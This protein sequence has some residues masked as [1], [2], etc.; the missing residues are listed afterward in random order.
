[1]KRI[2][3]LSQTWGVRALV[4]LGILSVLAP[5]SGAG[6]LLFGFL[7][8]AKLSGP[9]RTEVVAA[10]KKTTAGETHRSAP[11]EATKPPLTKK[12]VETARRDVVCSLLIDNVSIGECRNDVETGFQS[13]VLVAVFVS[14]VDPPIGQNIEITVDG[15]TKI[16]NP[17]EKGCANYVQF[18][19]DADGSSQVA[20]AEFSGG[21]C[22][23]PSVIFN[24]P[25]EC[26]G[27]APC[28]GA[29]SIGGRV[30][31]DFDSD[32]TLDASEFGLEGAQ[33][34]LYDNNENLLCTATT[35]LQ[36]EWTCTGLTA[37]QAVRA[38]ISNFPSGYTPAGTGIDNN[39][40][41]V[42]FA[43]VGSDCSVDFG[44][45]DAGN[46]C[47]NNPYVITPCYVRGDPQGGGTS[48]MMDV[49][50]AV[51]YNAE[52]NTSVN[53]YLALNSEAGSMWGVAYQKET[54][55]LFSSA[56]L[57]RHCG[58]G[59]AGLGGIYVTDVSTI[60]APGGSNTGL[61]STYFNLDAYGINTGNEASLARNLGPNVNQ[62]TYDGQVFDLVGKW[63]L[64]DID[65]S[66]DGD[67]L[68]IV[69]MHNRSLVTVAIG[70]PAVTP[71]PASAVSE[72]T[73]PDP[74]CSDASD[75]RPF[76]LKYNNGKIYVGGVCSAQTS[77]DADD[78]QAII[79][80]YSPAAGTFTEILN[81]PLGYDK[82]FVL[83]GLAHCENWNPW[84]NDFNDLPAGGIELCY[85]QPIL[86]DIEF[87]VYG[88]M[89]VAFNDRGGHQMGWYDYGTTP[90]STQTWK[91]NSGGDVLRVVNNNGTWLIERNATAGYDD[92]CGA[93]NGQ[94][95]CGG[96]FYCQDSYLSAHQEAVHGGIAVHPSN[97]EL[98]LNMM[99]ATSAFSGGLAWYNN[100]S[101]LKNR[102]YRVYFSD[103]N[104]DNGTN[105]KAAG[106]GDVEIL[107]GEAPIEIGN[108]VWADSDRDGIMDPGEPGLFG[109]NVALYKGGNLIATTT[110][111][112][113]GQYKF[114]GA[115]VLPNM[116]YCVAF[117]TGGQFSNGTLSIGGASYAMTLSN[118]G[119]GVNSDNNDSDVN[120]GGN[121][122]PVAIQGLPVVCLVTGNY[123]DNDNTFDAGFFPVIDYGDLPDNNTAGTYPTDATNGG[124]EGVGPSHQI[125]PT[126]KM[127]A[128]VDFEDGG[129][130]SALANGDDTNGTPDDENGVTLPMFVA[131]QSVNVPVVVM[132]MTGSVAKLTGFFDW[133]KN[134]NLLD[135]GEMF[136]LNVPNGTNGTV[137]LAVAV[138]AGAVLNM[139]LGVRFRLSTNATVSMLPTGA[140]PDGEVEDYLTQVMAF[141]FGDLPDNNTAGSYPTDGTNG[142]GEG[143]GASHKINGT[144]K[145]GANVDFENAGQ[146]SALA[147][148]DDTN[149]SDDENGIAAFPTF[150][151]GQPATLSVNAMNM[152]GSAAVLYAYFDWNKDGDFNDVNEVVNVPVPDGTNGNVSVSVNVPLTATTNMNLGVRFRLSNDVLAAG[153]PSGP[154]PN[155][156][157]ED[158]VVLVLCQTLELTTVVDNPNCFGSTDGSINLTV[159]GG[160]GTYTYDWSN[161]GPETPDNDPMDLV[162]IG[163]GN[164]SVTVTDQNGCDD[165]TSV[166]VNQPT[167]LVPITAVTNVSCNGGAD[168]AIDLGI[169]GGTPPYVYDWSNDGPESPDTDNQDLAGLTE[170]SYTVTITDINGCV[171]T[172]GATLSQ[173]VA[174]LNLTA[175]QMN[176]SCNTG[177][178]GSINLSVS[179]GTSPYTYDWSNDGEEDPDNDNQD[180]SGLT[181][182]LYSVTVTDANGCSDILNIT[183]TEP[184]PVQLST[185]IM[186][187]PCTSGNNGGIVLTV[188]GGTPGYTY[189]W[190]NDGPDSP[191]N[192]PKDLTNVPAGT[193]TV[194]VT[195]ANLC[196]AQTSV[197]VDEPMSGLSLD[198]AVANV[199][200]SGAFDLTVG[201]GTPVYSY[202][203][204]NDGPESPDND[205]QDVTVT[206]AGTYTVT[207][208]DANGCTAEASA[209][210][211]GCDYGDLADNNTPGSYPTD[212]VN[213]A[214][215]GVG[216]SHNIVPGIKMGA[217]V[218]AEAGGA[219]SANAN[220]D[221]N[222]GSDDENGVAAFPMFV[223]GQTVTVSVNV[224]N[225]N[226]DDEAAKLTAYFDWNADGDF[227]D[228]GEMVSASVP[229]GTNGIIN[230]SVPVPI[231]TSLNSNLGTRFR[232]STDTDASM[233]PTGP[234][235]DGE[236]EDYLIQVMA[237]DYGDLADNNAAGSYPTDATNGAGEGVGASHKIIAG[238]K[239]GAIVDPEAAGQP[240]GLANGDDAATSDDEDGVTLPMFLA[241]QSYTVPVVVMNM[242]GV[243]AKLTGFFDW[244][245]N[246]SLS[247]AGEM[248]SINVPTGTNGTVNLSVSVPIDA[249]LN[250]PLGARF[251]LSTDA[252]ASMNPSG[253][254]PDGEVEDYQVTAVMAFDYGDLPDGNVPGDYPTDGNNSNG[255]GVGPSH[256]I[257]AGLKLGNIVDIDNFGVPSS[258]AT[259][260]D[261]PNYLGQDDEDGVIL[262]VFVA[263]QTAT[264]SVT[265][266]NMT[267][268]PA[269]LY[270]YFDF[271]RDGDFADA[272]ET[273]SVPVPNGTNGTFNVPVSVPVSAKLNTLLGIRFRLTNDPAFSGLATGSA[274]S[275]EVEDYVAIVL[276]D[277]Y[278]DLPDT[279]GTSGPNA[280]SHTVSPELTLG[281]CVDNEA[282]GQPE[283]MAGMMTGGDDNTS[284]GTT[285]GTCAVGSDDENGIVFETPLLPGVEACIRVTATNTT[286]APAFLQ[287]WI[288]FNGDGDLLDGGEALSLTGGGLIPNGGVNN[289]QFCFTVPA[290]A[291]FQGGQAMVRFR[292][293]STGGLAPNNG[294]A[295][296]GEIEDY[297]VAL[298]KIGTF[299]WE[300]TNGDGIQNEPGTS[301]INGASVQLVWAGPDNNLATNGD[302]I[303]FATTTSTMGGFAG[304]YMFLGL[305]PGTYRVGLPANPAGGFLPTATNQ[306][307]DDQ[308][309]SDLA[310]GETFVV[311]VNFNMPL[312]EDGV[313]DVPGG[314][315]GFPDV[316]DN[317]TFDFG[318]Y[319]PASISNYTWI[320]DNGN[321]IQDQDEDPLPNVPVTLTG[322]TGSGVP[323]NQNTTTDGSGL[324][325]VPNLA[326]GSYKLTFGTPAGSDYV[327]TDVNQ[328]GNDASDSDA[329][330][331]MAGMTVFEVLTSGENNTTYDA[332]FYI[333]AE[334]G[335]Y[336]W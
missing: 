307:G 39:G 150:T 78:L 218:D 139:D 138:P 158:Y 178:N 100:A 36:G 188:T 169:S 253:P 48:G 104:G 7:P 222:A 176:V 255:E 264:A 289:Q 12:A 227:N 52:G 238:L 186:D 140:A 67:S 311:P 266:M 60:P 167:V 159:T 166:V 72:L 265:A 316:Q 109:V 320:D 185:A 6:N 315:N 90:P 56:F 270:V 164:Y 279:Y 203:W 118:I 8:T 145:L 277:D 196:T 231:G 58:W 228:A 190:S 286:G 70:N 129:Q 232:L 125:I 174:G 278:G 18:I 262:P 199:N 290:G 182:G 271:N 46:F 170:G 134:G 281:G 272:G 84:T 319:E 146:P 126:L 249:V 302:N 215:E 328:G 246:G 153:T 291:T 257:V 156:E 10:A 204:S 88:N 308:L 130:S 284:D 214:G 210:Y 133:N 24:L 43:T 189:D 276:G 293:S 285:I 206:V 330:P 184:T 194:T 14:W 23:A 298:A 234:A 29:T 111:N 317:L 108:Y 274:N 21:T 334:I 62:P 303:T 321:G 59:P 304:Q 187:V 1:M 288:D 209:P 11:M 283:P 248:V 65:I 87:D 318:Y 101:G 96:E 242:T 149:G 83:T 226:P 31:S 233:S 147:N 212:A 287:A 128:S 53:S 327:S 297:K 35:D 240:S 86:S 243:Q 205:A 299:V 323:V 245:A 61:I 280:P 313:G 25:A 148:G 310:A 97:N 296:N 326:P 201:G 179:G 183:I 193:Y 225:M 192:D 230:L 44:L 50:V 137:N 229:Q 235:P 26:A 89:M 191:D 38:E 157:V 82:G 260:D 195:D 68:F 16:I 22:S 4:A 254:A 28:A 2:S 20:D 106:L 85:P 219:S 81:S 175:S 102:A 306:G 75:W 331:A 155:G 99:D 113:S 73:I 173:P 329:D 335:N 177:A 94:G 263:G 292:L 216:A 127:G 309:D 80:E 237:F 267:G 141:D 236:V 66:E 17:A 98:L 171:T 37:G 121:T 161:D 295:A 114:S 103:N 13:K 124:G 143:I 95:P 64:G 34:D 172:T 76:A 54:K 33:I 55:K 93:G 324:Y 105:G 122:L 131:G 116:A 181:A 77:Q 27:S 252:T 325:N 30:Y 223:A 57:K 261:A 314:T 180:I 119:F 41:V 336:T 211:Y 165:V 142:A 312:N 200:C 51:P 69:N 9:V 259:A 208:T 239:I 132:N 91:G 251:R 332:G 273:F 40:G 333:P 207:V 163:A 135:A 160:T 107:C 154:A 268:T 152:T 250:T 19:L 168:G 294:A 275:G 15:Q 115:N 42:Q 136:S 63:G 92:G 224:M 45:L 3:T 74:G 217:T 120:P 197:T 117:G 241:N 32:G 79:Y 300:D 202:D 47:E 244:N 5:I 221:D 301:G 162:N 256:K 247:D 123:G 110:T 269:T 71:V 282:G 49:L 258:N 151:A 305:T 144:L 220:G 198:I 112:I 213:G 322:T